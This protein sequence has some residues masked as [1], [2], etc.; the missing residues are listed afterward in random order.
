MNATDWAAV[1]SLA[2]APGT[3]ILAVAA[4]RDDPAF[5]GNP[6]VTGVT[7]DQL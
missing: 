3:L 4:R 6:Q 7:S 2:T 5:T 1:A